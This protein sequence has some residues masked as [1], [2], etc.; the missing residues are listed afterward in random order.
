MQKFV[1]LLA[2]ISRGVRNFAPSFGFGVQ[3]WC[4]K[5]QQASSGALNQEA[6]VAALVSD[7]ANRAYT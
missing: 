3:Q 4:D 5:S 2:E 1:A 6:E 7:A